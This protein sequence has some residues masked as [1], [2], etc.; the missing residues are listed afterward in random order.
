[1]YRFVLNDV[2]F[3]TYYSMCLQIQIT[4]VRPTIFVRFFVDVNF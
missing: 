3:K 2:L 4:I 1:M